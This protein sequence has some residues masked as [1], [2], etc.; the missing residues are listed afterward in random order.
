MSH[1][2]GFETTITNQEALVRALCRC[3]SREG[4]IFTQSMIETHDKATHLYGYHGDQRVQTANVIIRRV[5]VGSA[6]ND[7]GFVKN[8]DGKFQAII[9]EYDS[10]YYDQHWL[11]KLYTYYNVETSKMEYESR[12][13]EYTESKDDAGRIQ[14]RAKFQAPANQSRIKTH[15]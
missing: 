14:L 8:K 4:Q 3:N 1:Y 2:N 9:S 12:G 7:L 11:T 5:H 10:G 13:I 6:S 15:S